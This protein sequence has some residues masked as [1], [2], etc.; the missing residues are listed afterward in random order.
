MVGLEFM[1]RTKYFFQWKEK[2]LLGLNL[3]WLLSL[4]KL[5]VG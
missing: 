3:W 1:Q 5:N 4:I 2:Q